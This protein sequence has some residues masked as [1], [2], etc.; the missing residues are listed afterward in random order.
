MWTWLTPTPYVGKSGF[1]FLLLVHL[2][3]EFWDYQARQ[4]VD[5]CYFSI[6]FSLTFVFSGVF[7]F[8]HLNFPSF[9]SRAQLERR[10]FLGTQRLF[11]VVSSKHLKIEASIWLFLCRVGIQPRAMH[12]LSNWVASPVSNKIRPI[13]F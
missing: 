6:W 4:N 10:C 9:R 7:K 13:Y 11:M 12:I 2:P 3:P 1:K 5:K 8:K